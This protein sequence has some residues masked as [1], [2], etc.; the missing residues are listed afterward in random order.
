MGADKESILS[1]NGR[2]YTFICSRVQPF[3]VSNLLTGWISYLRTGYRDSLI[4]ES[5]LFSLSALLVHKPLLPRTG[6]CGEFQGDTEG[7][8]NI[9][10]KIVDITR[11]VRY[12]E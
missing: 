2:A 3:T 6:H 1:L 5:H 4:N 7:V 9:F 11:R 10:G 12:I 8:Q